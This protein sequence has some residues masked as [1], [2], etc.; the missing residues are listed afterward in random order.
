MHA[1]TKC[2]Q[3]AL[4]NF[5]T[6]VQCGRQMFMNLAL[7]ACTTNIFTIIIM[8]VQVAT[9]IWSITL[10]FSMM[11]LG[12]SLTL[13]EASFMMLLVQPLLKL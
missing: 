5:V 3:N 10:K 12:A 1:P 13:L 6:D 7:V 8:I 2:F 4:A 9:T 11:L